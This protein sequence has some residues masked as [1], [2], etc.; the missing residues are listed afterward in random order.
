MVQIVATG[1]KLQRGARFRRKR[2]PGID[3]GPATLPAIFSYFPS[4]LSIFLAEVVFT[5]SACTIPESI[6]FPSLALIRS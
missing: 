1:G 3:P 6:S 2:E 4:I 5:S